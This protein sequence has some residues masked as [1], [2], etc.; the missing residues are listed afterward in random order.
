MASLSR[1]VA[2]SFS[3]LSLLSYSVSTINMSCLLVT[4]FS[5]LRFLSNSFHCRHL[6]SIFGSGLALFLVVFCFLIFASYPQPFFPPVLQVSESLFALSFS[7][8]SERFFFKH[9][10][11]ALSVA[12]VRHSAYAFWPTTDIPTYRHIYHAKS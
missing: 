5:S 1:L 6:A 10:S 11:A 9:A 4:T 12:C 2:A 3:S 8:I 7:F